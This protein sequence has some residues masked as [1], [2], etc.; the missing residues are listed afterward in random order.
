MT[1]N[2]FYT[3]LAEFSLFYYL[4]RVK[5]GPNGKAAQV[6]TAPHPTHTSLSCPEGEGLLC[7]IASQSPSTFCTPPGEGLETEAWEA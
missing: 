1:L 2:Y 4:P 5:A 3:E 6:Q 7:C